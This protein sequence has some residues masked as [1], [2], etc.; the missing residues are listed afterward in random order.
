MVFDPIES[1]N[2]QRPPGP[3]LGTNHDL[4]QK[5]RTLILDEDYPFLQN[6]G[7]IASRP[8]SVTSAGKK[9]T[10]HPFFSRQRRGKLFSE[11]KSGRRRMFWYH[12][13]PTLPKKG[14]DRY[15]TQ[16]YFTCAGLGLI[17]GF[18]PPTGTLHPSRPVKELITIKLFFPG[19]KLPHKSMK[20]VPRSLGLKVARFV[21]PRLKERGWDGDVPVFLEMVINE[22]VYGHP[23]C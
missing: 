20:Q 6:I 12:E 18:S 14:P 8:C 15:N 19:W 21:L 2:Y 5:V 16:D 7:D 9:R 13:Q 4:S 3:D 1:C 23:P 22:H 11:M 17:Y 10:L